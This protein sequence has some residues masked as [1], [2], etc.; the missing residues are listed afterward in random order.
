MHKIGKGW[1]MVSRGIGMERGAAPRVRIFCP[2]EL[3]VI[4]LCPPGKSRTQ[5]AD[6]NRAL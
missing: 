2:P 3:V 6:E 5:E 1:L 4:E